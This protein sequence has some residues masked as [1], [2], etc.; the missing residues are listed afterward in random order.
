VIG[1]ELMVCVK[2]LMTGNVDVA[3]LVRVTVAEAEVT[4]VVTAGWAA[5]V[6]V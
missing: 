6:A 4:V 1:Q 2:G 5:A 3:V